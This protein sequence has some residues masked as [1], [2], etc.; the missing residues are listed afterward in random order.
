MLGP[1]DG[2]AL[3]PVFTGAPDGFPN[4]A[5]AISYQLIFGRLKG[6]AGFN[7]TRLGIFFAFPP[8]VFIARPACLRPLIDYRQPFAVTL[9]KLGSMCGRS[10]REQDK[11]DHQGFHFSSL[12]CVEK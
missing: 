12:G 9:A 11:N 2:V 10:L 4:D 8:A 5:V 1:I 6:L 3:L 7:N